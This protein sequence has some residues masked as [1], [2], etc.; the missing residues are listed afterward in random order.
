M[1]VTAGA[2]I[3]ALV[4]P[5]AQ[6]VQVQPGV[7]SLL[8]ADDD[9]LMEEIRARPDA[10]REAFRELFASATR[11]V[12]GERRV[13][14][15]DQARR[16][17]RLYHQVWSD[18]FFE[19]RVAQFTRWSLDE[20]AEMLEADSLRLAGNAAFRPRGPEAAIVLWERSLT[21]LRALGD[22]P[23]EAAVL[24]NLGAGYQLLGRP[25]RSLRYHA[26]ALELAEASGD[27]R[28]RGNALGNIAAVHQA[29]GDLALAA[30]YYGRALEVRPLTG[31]LAGELADL[32]NL[33]AV[34]ADLGDSRGAEE[35]L[36]RAL[37]LNRQHG[38]ER[39]AANNLTNL[40]NLATEAGG[41]D[42]ALSLYDEAL[43]LLRRV[44]DRAG[45][46]LVLEN[47]GRLHLRWGDYPSAL[48]SL[49]ASLAILREIGPPI[50]RAEV[51]ADLAAVRAAMGQLREAIPL[52]EQAEAEAGED[53]SL[54]AMLTLQR[55]DLLAD[56][57]EDEKAVELYQRAEA[58]YVRLSDPAG[59]A[60]ARQGLGYLQMSREDF[61]AAE[62]WFRRALRAQSALEDPRPAALTHVLLGD[63]RAMGGDVVAAGESYRRALD[64]Y[65]ALGDRVGEAMTL[66]ALAD[67][68]RE[69]G[70]LAS[71][72]STYRTALSKIEDQPVQP[73]RW[74]LR[75]GLG[76][77]LREQGRLGEAA[78]ELRAA[79]TE[80]ERVGMTLSAGTRRY[81]YLE[82]KW[83]AYAELAR[84]EF[85]QGRFA[86]A[87]EVSERMRARELLDIL[88]RGRTAHGTGSAAGVREE[89]TLRRRI[90]ELASR[91]SETLGLPGAPR[92]RTGERAETAGLRQAH[93]TSQARHERLLAD[94][95]VSEPDYVSMVRGT[96]AGYDDVQRL[97]PADGT[98]IE[99]LVSDRWTLAFVVSAEAVRAIELPIGRERLHE[100]IRFLRGAL[101]PEADGG[102]NELW[103]TP[104]RSLHESLVSPLEEAGVLDGAR[105]LVVAPHRELHYL[106]FAALLRSG[107]EGETFLIESYDV[108]YV[109]SGSAW[110]QLSR[111]ARPEPGRG[112]LAMAPIPGTLRGSAEEV[113]AIARGAPGTE[114]LVGPAATEARFRTLAPHRSVLHLATS[115]VLNGRNPLFSYVRLNAGPGTDGRLE[116]HEVF[117]LGL[118]ADLVVLSAC[119]T[120]LGSGAHL[121]VPPGDDWVGLVRAFLAAGATS[122]VASLWPVEDAATA[123]LMVQ[124]YDGLGEGHTKPHALARAQRAF[125]RDGSRS[126]PFYWAAFGLTGDVGPPS[127]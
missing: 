17:A 81:R 60:E 72:A 110:A 23:G 22:L 57:N 98:L 75:F 37:A 97:L 111:R 29:G 54:R 83:S 42:V 64:A 6:G 117:D 77:T 118:S 50:R 113:R 52:L 86:R 73:I 103:R 121:E 44:D 4:A 102:G 112:V 10:V 94:L 127:L 34:R 119:E 13:H 95:E 126:N 56:L 92:G 59:Q 51:R 84:T 33:A 49:A 69:A 89:Q 100:L 108:A 55:A 67:L 43:G 106:P 91:L 28:T 62:E 122:V 25:D 125:I 5:V 26:R 40:A 114:L 8:E 124:F 1:G 35:Q 87:F 38:R 63:V 31:D 65:V 107:P 74:R 120:G 70:D 47:T 16:L 18:P 115:G 61:D 123:G 53:E 82:D 41:Y 85:D 104:L 20:R 58:A 30:E 24:G 45:E 12:D 14:H 3:L 2:L 105:L 66:G 71:S 76:R 80:V 116:V 93:L 15:L 101:R 48:E 88:A 96:P 9:W 99:Y 46:A 36:R 7:L 78:T 39:A 68:D 21:K 32:N 109:P 79:V 90:G 19:R 11:A 27:H